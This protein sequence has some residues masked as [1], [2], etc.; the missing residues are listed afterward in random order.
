MLINLLYFGPDM[1]TLQISALRV[2]THIGV[3]AWEQRILQQLL[4]DI[5]IPIDVTLCNNQLDHTLD[6]DQL[7]QKV[8]TYLESNSFKLIETVAEDLALFIKNEF[9]VKT[10]TITVSKPHAIKNADRISVTISR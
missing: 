10:L 9:K 7:C 8:T 6:Y 1:D 3:H 4:L 2:M 5:Q